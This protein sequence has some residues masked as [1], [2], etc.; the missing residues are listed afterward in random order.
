MFAVLY[1]ASPNAHQGGWRWVSPGGVLAVL[2]WIVVSF[3]F[4]L[5]VSHFGSYDKTYGTLGGVIVFLIW[6]WLSN[7]AILFG[8]ELNA[9]LERQRVAAA[10]FPADREPY[11]R[12]REDRKLR[13]KANDSNG[14]G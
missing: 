14:S 13:G 5:Y 6:L 9:E 10:G 8:A 2:L 4:G 3:L 1:R 7:L 12:L 11:L